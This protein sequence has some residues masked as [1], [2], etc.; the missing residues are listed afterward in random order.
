M[1]EAELRAKVSALRCG[2]Q[3]WAGGRWQC[4]AT[5]KAVSD[6]V[7]NTLILLEFVPDLG[8]LMLMC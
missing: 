4:V 1:L 3:C 6:K 8:C 2:G 7:G 5:R